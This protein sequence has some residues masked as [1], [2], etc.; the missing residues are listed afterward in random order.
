MSTLDTIV[1][2]T[3]K[4]RLG[5]TEW[6]LRRVGERIDGESKTWIVWRE[7]SWSGRPLGV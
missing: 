5:V 7:A 3:I 4:P 2:E 6:D 1:R